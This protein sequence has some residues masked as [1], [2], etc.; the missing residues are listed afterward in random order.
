MENNTGLKSLGFKRNKNMKRFFLLIALSV[1]AVTAYAQT[2]TWSGEIET[3][4]TKL[5]LVFHLDG[6]KPTMDSPDQSVRGIPISVER[7]AFGKVKISIPSI[8]AGYEGILFGNNIVG[9]FTQMGMS[10]PLTLQPGEVKLSRPQTPHEPFP[11]STEEVSFNNGG[12]TLNGTLVLPE[13]CSRQ[14]PVLLFIT[15]SGRQN[16]DEEIFEHRP[17]AVIADAFAREGI[18]TL[19][20]DDRGAGESTGVFADATIADF[21]DD[22][23]SGVNYLKN[24]FDK[25]GVIGHSEGGTIAMMLA[26]GNQVDF[27]ISLAGM[28]VSGAETLVWQNRI[29]LAAA[30]FTQPVIDTYCKAIGE[31]FEVITHGGRMPQADALDLPDVLKKNFLA[32]LNQIQSPYMKQ[33][34]ATDVRPSLGTIGCPVLALNGTMDN[35]VECNSNLE[36]LRGGL[37]DNPVSRIVPVE[38]V[39]HLFQHCKT[40]AVTEYRDIEETF[41]PEVLEIMTDW[42]SAFK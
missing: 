6:D 15:G 13:G 16:R 4:G 22:A 41:A 27:A 35:Q 9:S 26:A 19:R 20:Y 18:A 39:N 38:G 37:R 42:L 11:Y 5:S 32:V 24:R 40:G 3:Q 25:V 10:L 12:V 21:R 2:G 34:I 17:F 31:S 30:G 36:A 7:N 8:S 29:A 33:F 23:L 1:Y 14:T 28:A